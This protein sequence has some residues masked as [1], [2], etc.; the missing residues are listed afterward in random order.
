MNLTTKLIRTEV[1][2]P[3]LLNSANDS[4]YTRSLG[5]IAEEKVVD[6]LFICR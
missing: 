1:G 6:S 4:C 2:H 3:L 5:K